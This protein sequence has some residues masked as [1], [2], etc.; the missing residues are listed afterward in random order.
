[1]IRR[2]SLLFRASC[3]EKAQSFLARSHAIRNI[4]RRAVMVGYNRRNSSVM[5]PAGTDIIT[6]FS[7]VSPVQYLAMHKGGL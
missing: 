5:Q 4:A 6:S 7:A 2:L 3:C 1:M